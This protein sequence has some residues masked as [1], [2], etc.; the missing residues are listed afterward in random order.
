MDG[1]GRRRRSRWDN[2]ADVT[3]PRGTHSLSS[4]VPNEPP[5]S[6][7][8]WLWLTH[9]RAPTGRAGFA[10]RLAKQLPLSR[11]QPLDG[12]R[13]GQPDDLVGAAVFLLSDSA[14]FVTGQ[15]LDIDGGWSVSEGL[16]NNPLP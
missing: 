4:K 8:R 9:G 16:A 5:R 11:K 2:A 6:A 7:T 15:V 13:M 12:G 14:K 1:S 10:V 3:L